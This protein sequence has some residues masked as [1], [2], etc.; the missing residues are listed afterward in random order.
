MNTNKGLCDIPIEK[1]GDE[2]LNIKPYVESL[3]EFI[4]ECDTPM[5]IAIQGDWG[6]GKTSMMNMIREKISDSVCPIWFNTW[7]YSQFNAQDELG[8]ILLTHFASEI[9]KI[10][11]KEKTKITDISEKMGVITKSIAR[12]ALVGSLS[13]VAGSEGAKAFNQSLSEN[14]Q[15]NFVQTLSEL[16]DD[17]AKSVKNRIE[18]EKKENKDRI[19]VFIDDLDR[20]VPE[21]TVEL[22]EVFKNFLDI[23]GCV[24]V[25]ACDYHVI[26]QG[27][28][29]KFGVSGTELKG[30]S[31]FD[32]IIQLPFSMPVGLYDIEK[33]T[34]NLLEKIGV[35]TEPDGE[36]KKYQALIK[37]SVGVNPRSMKRLF[38][39]FQLIKSTADKC[40]KEQENQEVVATENQQLCLLLACLCMQT[41]FEPVYHHL[42]KHVYDGDPK[43]FLENIRNILDIQ[44][45]KSDDLKKDL[46][47]LI[48][49]MGGEDSL[50]VESLPNFME[51]FN[52]AIQLDNDKEISSDEISNLM[53]VLTL[54]S[55]TATISSVQT[56]SDER[57]DTILLKNKLKEL[58]E[59]INEDTDFEF[60][61]GRWCSQKD[62]AY[63]CIVTEMKINNKKFEF[64]CEFNDREN[65]IGVYLS[66][67]NNYEETF[68][69][70]DKKIGKDILYK[71]DDQRDQNIYWLAY[72]DDLKEGTPFGQKFK[73]FKKM[74]KKCIEIITPVIA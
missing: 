37:S 3:S 33:Y 21:R 27:L 70:L 15:K 46:T 63:A 13:F 55:I 17:I 11:N 69:F 54:S 74:V 35:K 41:S 30:K 44:K 36:L 47:K 72:H 5:T 53:K 64:T 40:K 26:E 39:S 23:K 66:K 34:K 71:E 32:K 28:K 18:E 16:K 42:I 58:A 4:K 7:Q 24:F 12:G 50:M 43:D 9:S 1:L 45:L 29:K 49:E 68:N 25:L 59:E 10:N 20:L 73:A 61:L 65:Y 38:N 14:F 19:V 62:P 56:N 22:L 51:A 2:N 52:N 6:S 8:F 57:K 60:Y 31:F 67:N 48:K